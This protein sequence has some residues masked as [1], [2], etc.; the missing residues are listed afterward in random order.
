MVYGKYIC[1]CTL[2]RRVW[3]GFAGQP[4]SH[5]VSLDPW[6]KKFLD[7]NQRLS[8]SRSFPQAT[9]TFLVLL[10]IREPQAPFDFLVLTFHTFKMT[11]GFQKIFSNA[12][13]VPCIIEHNLAN[14]PNALSLHFWRIYI[15]QF[16]WNWWCF[17]NWV[18]HIVTVVISRLKISVMA[19]LRSPWNTEFLVLSADRC[20]WSKIWSC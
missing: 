12:K 7:H 9:R 14:K 15:L 17:I 16:G 20:S 13:N 1:S 10:H 2:G 6:G 18:N 19:N 11:N 8:W 5:K 4:I 3:E